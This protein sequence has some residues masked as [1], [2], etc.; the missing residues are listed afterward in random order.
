MKIPKLALIALYFGAISITHAQIAIKGLSIDMNIDDA[1]KVVNERFSAALDN[2]TYTIGEPP[3]SRNSKIPKKGFALISS[4]TL[5]TKD[6]PMNAL[7]EGLT[8]K[9]KEAMIEMEKDAQAMLASI[10][11]EEGAPLVFLIIADEEK[12]VYKI[13]LPGT[14]TDK[15]FNTEDMRP[16][17]FVLEII[18]NYNIPTMS[19]FQIE[20]GQKSF[21]GGEY[22]D[23]DGVRLR[24]FD[25]KSIEMARIPKQSSRSF[26]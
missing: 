3:A 13:I 24:V 9:D 4:K 8:E 7:T 6:I 26:D 23:P 11:M 2:N 21:S 20:V 22:F 15:L 14:L 16:D 5:S 10:A 25:D 12:K 17:D 18:K 19:P 1:L